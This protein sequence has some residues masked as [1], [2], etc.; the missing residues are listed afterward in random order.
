EPPA[1]SPI[2]KQPPSKTEK[3]SPVKEPGKPQPAKSPP[4]VKGNASQANGQ[5]GKGFTSEEA[6][7]AA[8]V[9]N[10]RRAAIAAAAHAAKGGLPPTAGNRDEAEIEASDSPLLDLSD[11]AVKKMIKG[12]KK[13]G[14]VTYDQLNGVMPSEEVTSEK[15]EDVLSMLNDMGINVIESEEAEDADEDDDD[16]EGGEL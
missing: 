3:Q 10:I 11:A 15:I 4:P 16:E 6:R 2:L 14:Y 8:G 9:E 12:A 13:R 7:T 1:K 5:D